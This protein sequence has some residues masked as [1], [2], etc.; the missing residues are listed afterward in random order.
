MQG[1]MAYSITTCFPQ[2]SYSQATASPQRPRGCGFLFRLAIDA[3]RVAR[4]SLSAL[5][6]EK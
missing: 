6:S 5:D 1:C 2:V 3:F 4:D